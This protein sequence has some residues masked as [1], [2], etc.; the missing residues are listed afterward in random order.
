[1][2][3][4]SRHNL[5]WPQLGRGHITNNHKGNRRFRDLVALHRADYVAA[6]KIQKPAV[7]RI[8]VKAIRNGNPPGR[9]LRKDDDTGHWYDVGTC[10]NAAGTGL[11]AKPPGELGSAC[12]YLAD[13]NLNFSLLDPVRSGLILSLADAQ[14]TKRRQKRP[15]RP[16]ASGSR[17]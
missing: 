11:N 15:P 8:L 13:T 16:C 6:P 5:R 14:G 7:A 4:C 2:L 9:F 1:L 17:V 12:R 10:T 3:F